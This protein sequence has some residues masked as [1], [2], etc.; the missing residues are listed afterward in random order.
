[1]NIYLNKRLDSKN[2]MIYYFKPLFF[3][4]ILLLTNNSIAQD[5]LLL[6]PDSICGKDALLRSLSPNTNYSNNLDFNAHAWTNSGNPVTHRSL[7]EFDLSSIPPSS[8]IIGAYLSLYSYNSTVLGSHSTLSGSNEAVL[9]RITS[10]WNENTVT[11]GNQPPTSTINQVILPQSVNALQDYLNI[12]V[13]NMVQDIINNPSTGHG[14]LFK[15]TNEQYYRRMLF[16]SS[17]NPDP[18]LYPKLEVIYS[19]TGTVTQNTLNLGNDTILCPNDSILLDAS[20]SGATYLWQ[21]GSVNSTFN[22]TQQGTYWVEVTT[23][24]MVFYDTINVN[25]YP[26]QIINLSNDTTLCQGETM[27]LDATTLNASYLWQDGS[28]NPTFNITQQGSYWVELTVNTCSN[29]DTINI[30]YNSLPNFNIGND[31]LLCLGDNLLLDATL[32]N[33]SYLWQDNST[34][35][36]F[37]VNQQGTYWVELTVNNC[38][39]I[40]SINIGYVP[41]PVIDLGADTILCIGDILTIDASYPNASYLWSD[42]SVN[43]TY[44]ITQQGT[45]WVE[46][47]LNSCSI[48]DTINISNTSTPYVELGN[49]T[50]IC[51]GQSVILDATAP[52]ATYLWQD[53][54][55]N[56]IITITEQGTYSVGVSNQCGT[57]T[58]SMTLLIDNCGCYV[59]LPNVFTPDNNGMN[60]TFYPIFECDFNKYELYIFN[61]WGALIFESNDPY[62]RWDGIFKGIVVP[63]GVY[64]YLLKCTLHDNTYHQK[65]GHVTLLK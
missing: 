34:N 58:D 62:A 40:D 43:S 39:S 61:R 7:I 19:S 22:V 29:S 13:T 51:V 57:T 21:D 16:A 4:L 49:D 9:Q 38:S 64:V 44:N 5:T 31:T 17:D 28:T 26:P 8:T 54:S 56:P 25:Y 52:N 59:Y 50:T 30:T 63:T 6:Q 12:D 27:I 1:M 23:C 53:G 60:D 46:V 24:S 36:T 20:T 65:H 32:T 10:S 37:N 2:V 14:F 33:A 18:N 3:V 45:F 15:L 47:T 11:W 48:T 55:I 35:S 41:F 42:G